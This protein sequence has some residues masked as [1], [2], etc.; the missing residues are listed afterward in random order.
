MCDAGRVK[1]HLMHC[2]SDLKNTVLMVGYCSPNTLGAKLLRGEKSVRIYGDDFEVKAQ[3]ESIHSYSAH[4][5]YS[6]LIRFLSCQ[7]KTKV[8]GIFLVHGETESKVA[9]KEKLLTEGYKH[10]SIP[11]KTEHYQLD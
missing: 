2:I 3:I 5:D 9:F 7:D 1:H 8:K 11:V 6:E 10:V 4:G